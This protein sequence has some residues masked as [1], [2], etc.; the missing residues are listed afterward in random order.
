MALEVQKRCDDMKK[1]KITQLDYVG[2]IL[3]FKQPQKCK[4]HNEKKYKRMC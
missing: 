3:I 4:T 2:S 1:Y